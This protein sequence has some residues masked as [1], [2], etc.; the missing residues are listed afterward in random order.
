[1]RKKDPLN[2]WAYIREVCPELCTIHSTRLFPDDK[3]FVHF[4]NFLH[5]RT[6]LLKGESVL[7]A[8]LLSSMCSYVSAKSGLMYPHVFKL[9]KEERTTQ[10]CGYKNIID[11]LIEIRLGCSIADG[12][13]RN[14]ALSGQQVPAIANA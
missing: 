13:V 9:F 6:I 8:D 3:L 1:M 2:H 11:G 14:M 5:E 12:Y 4:L 10:V 7:Y